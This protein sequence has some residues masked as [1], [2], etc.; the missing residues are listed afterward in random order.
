LSSLFAV[1]QQHLLLPF[2]Q[3]EQALAL[4]LE[5]LG[6]LPQG[7]GEAGFGLAA[8]LAEQGLVLLPLVEYLPLQIED[9]ILGGL[10]A[11]LEHLW[12]KRIISY[13]AAL[14]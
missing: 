1:L 8:L 6:H 14:L 12:F 7:L 3:L 10:G 4:L 5:S 11:L 13:N 9:L 2:L